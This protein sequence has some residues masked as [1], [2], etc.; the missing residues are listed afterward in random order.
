MSR[1]S[2]PYRWQHH[3]PALE[4]PRTLVAP[5]VEELLG[6]GAAVVIGGRGMGKS[7]LLNQVGDTL[8]RLR[9]VRVLHF[10]SPP[11]NL[12]AR[13][14][15]ETL[16]DGL[17]EPAADLRTSH[18]LLR[19]FLGRRPAERL[20]L[21]YDEFDRYAKAPAPGAPVPGQLFFNDLESAR[22]SLGR[23]GILAVGT[24]GV[25]VF[26]DVL[27]SS[28]LSRAA[29][30]WMSPFER[31][32]A[33]LLARPF[34]DR[35]RGLDDDVLETLYLASGGSPALLTYGLQGAWPFAEP[36][37]LDVAEIFT[38]FQDRYGEFLNDVVEAFSDPA[39]S[40]I[41]QRVWELIRSRGGPVARATLEEVCRSAGGALRLT[42]ADV[43]HL[44]QAAGLIRI[45][46]SAISDDPIDV[47]PVASL[48]SLPGVSPPAAGF[49]ERLWRD[50]ETLLAQLF[51]SSA[52]FFRPGARSGDKRL[53]PESV[54][55][56]F[57][58][59]GFGLVGWQ[60]EREAQQVA[61]R[62][63]LKLRRNGSAEIGIVEVKIWGRRGYREAH[64]QVAKYW[65]PQ[66]IA[67]AVVMLTD[68]EIPDWAAAYRRKCLDGAGAVS[69]SVLPEDSAVHARFQARSTTPD[70]LTT[71]VEHFLL[72]LPRGI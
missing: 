38:R 52:D 68:G 69:E 72:R 17:D 5:V 11:Q 34:E 16:A 18:E 51:A 35:G 12:S 65:T 56:A 6:G 20:I 70:G 24:L 15:L 31:G 3:E 67:G 62:T 29:R 63:D 1:S 27:G 14:C 43:L 47:H 33:R 2:N 19:R 58:A 13:D 39:L 10:P 44:L 28:F 26:R 50:L 40:Q 9:N 60:T 25:F 42:V 30:F 54:F 21:L 55:S 71:R 32:E 37:E 36:T 49:G 8:E 64:G 57:L 4:V 46:G 59:L 22:R 41:P 45:D 61:G 23:L 53:V 48:L 66:V 7:V